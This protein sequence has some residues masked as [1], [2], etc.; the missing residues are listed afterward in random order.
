VR[1][2]GLA[3]GLLG[4]PSADRAVARGLADRGSPLEDMTAL[5]PVG[6]IR[7]WP[8]NRLKADVTRGMAIP[9]EFKQFT[10]PHRPL[11]KRPEASR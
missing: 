2:G 10:E 3:G 11:R 8:E 4:R 5:G 9:T 7:D 6:D 1:C